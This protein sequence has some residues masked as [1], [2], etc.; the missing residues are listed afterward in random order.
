MSDTEEPIVGEAPE[1]EVEAEVEEEIIEE[2]V[3]DVK[4]VKL[5]GKWEFN[6]I[7]VRDIS[8]QVRR[9]RLYS[10]KLLH[11]NTIYST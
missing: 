10:N 1:A 8:L 7:E 2:E 3:T 9:K 6:E 11:Q 5:F 4:E